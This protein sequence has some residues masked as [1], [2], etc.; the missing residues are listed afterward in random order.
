EPHFLDLE[1]L[2]RLCEPRSLGGKSREVLFSSHSL[3]FAL[4]EELAALLS[5]ELAPSNERGMELEGLFAS[6]ASRVTGHFVEGMLHDG[7]GIGHPLVFA[8][9]SPEGMSSD[10]GGMRLCRLAATREGRF[11]FHLE[12]A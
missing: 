12:E 10:C 11:K 2:D 4:S 3:P 6:C 7:G 5:P 1:P 8:S 9:R